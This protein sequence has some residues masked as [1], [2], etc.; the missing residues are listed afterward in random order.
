MSGSCAFNLSRSISE[1]TADSNLS[2]PYYLICSSS[3]PGR[4][5]ARIAP[6][7]RYLNMGAAWALNRKHKGTANVNSTEDAVQH[8]FPYRVCRGRTGRDCR[9]NSNCTTLWKGCKL[10][11]TTLQITSFPRPSSAIYIADAAAIKVG[12]GLSWTRPPILDT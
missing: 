12:L 1:L 5:I 8:P 4:L 3:A 2:G 10:K 7:A 6:P 9:G 11:E